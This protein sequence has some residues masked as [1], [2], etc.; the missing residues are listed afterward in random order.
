MVRKFILT[1][2]AISSFIGTS[3]AQG[4]QA[5]GSQN[6]PFKIVNVSN[7][8]KN[9]F[10]KLCSPNSPVNNKII[11]RI[12]SIEREKAGHWFEKKLKTD[13]Y[14]TW[15]GP[16]NKCYLTMRPK[17]QHIEDHGN[18][19]GRTYSLLVTQFAVYPDGKS[20]IFETDY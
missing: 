17:W 11:N 3:P 5:S 10:A 15:S 9:E 20:F 14:I 13:F 2:L 6:L 4:Q 7:L 12:E 8:N 1:L 18:T 19:Y 16:N